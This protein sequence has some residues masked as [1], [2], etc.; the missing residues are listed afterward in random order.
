MMVFVHACN[1]IYK[2]SQSETFPLIHLLQLIR[3]KNAYE[4]PDWLFG[5]TDL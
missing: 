1:M 3:E 2:L 4:S 5:I